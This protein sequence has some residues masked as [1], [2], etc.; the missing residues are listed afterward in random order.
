LQLDGWADLR[1]PQ[2]QATVNNG[3]HFSGFRA[4]VN[5]H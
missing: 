1:K 2:R 5:T 4:T 3:V